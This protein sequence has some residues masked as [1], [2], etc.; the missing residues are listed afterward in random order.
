MLRPIV[1]ASAMAVNVGDVAE[2][3]GLTVTFQ[4]RM[5]VGECG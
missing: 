1:N 2:A 4:A 3:M 5:G